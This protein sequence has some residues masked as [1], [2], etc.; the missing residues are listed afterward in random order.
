MTPPA[1]ATGTPLAR[2]ALSRVE[3][4]QARTATTAVTPSIGGIALSEPRR[5]QPR[6]R[7]R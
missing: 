5:A 6:T 1:P 7:D 4:A 2:I 3:P